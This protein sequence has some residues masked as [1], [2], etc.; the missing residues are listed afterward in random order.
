MASMPSQMPKRKNSAAAPIAMVFSGSRLPS[1]RP[2][3]IA[4]A[5]AA[6]MPSVEPSQVPNQP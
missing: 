5:S 1:A 4:S 2:T 3:T 6:T